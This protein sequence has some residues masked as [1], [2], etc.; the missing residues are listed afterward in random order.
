MV[1]ILKKKAV[2]KALN[3]KGT[4]EDTAKNVRA[5]AQEAKGALALHK[6]R[7]PGYHSKLAIRVDN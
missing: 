2:K 6:N 1:N 4:K 3:G 7:K 5:K